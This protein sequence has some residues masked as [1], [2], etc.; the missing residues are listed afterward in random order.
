MKKILLLSFLLS[1]IFINAQQEYQSL[2]WEITGNSLEKPSYLY[3]TMHVSK[4]V[5]FRLDDVFYESLNKSECIAL[6]SDPSTWLA[7]NY[8]SSYLLNSYEPYN[9]DFYA[10]LFK[11]NHPKQLEIRENIRID[12]NQISGYLYRK[13][14]ADDN[15]EEETYLDMFIYQAG[16]KHNKTIVGLENLDESKYLTTKAQ[17]DDSKK[18]DA[19]LV[20]LFKE[21]RPYIVQE[22]TYRERNLD[23]LDSIG[24]ASS[25][26]FYREHMLY[27]RND[28]MVS[29]L[30]SLMHKKSVFSGVGAAHLPGKKGMINM[31]RE[32]GYIVKPLISNQTNFAEKEK[33]K[34]E[35]LFKKPKLSLQSTPDKFLTINSFDVLREYAFENKKF[36]LSPDMTNG[37]FLTISRINT[38]EYLPHENPI[39]LKKINDL[40]YEDV[41]G[42]IIRKEELIHPYPG[43][44]ILNK[45]KKGDYQKYHIYKTP[46]EIII[47]K[48]G[49]KK[50]FVLNY[51]ENIF[52]TITFQEKTNDISTYTDAHNKYSIVFPKYHVTDNT[53]NNGK[54]L[55]QGKNNNEYYFIQESP[56]HDLDYIE[57]D[58]FEAKHIHQ[59]FYKN[60]KI[61]ETKGNLKNSVYKSYESYAKIDSISNKKIFL[62]SIVKDASY[63]LLG[64]VG[65][66]QKKADDYFKS[67]KFKD[68]NYN[69]FKKVIDTSLHFSALT[70]AKPKL[71][72]SYYSNNKRKS[73]LETNKSTSYKT[74]ANE[75]IFVERTKYHDLQM[76]ENID[77]LWNSIDR[78]YKF[79]NLFYLQKKLKIYDK[80]K[81]AKN[82]MYTYSFKIKDS[83]SSKIISIKNIVKQGV[84]FELKTLS[85][86]LSKPSKFLTSFYDSFTPIDT[87]LGKNIFKDK[88]QIF[89]KALR[90]N[91]S[92][93]LRPYS[94]IKFK[95]HD[96]DSIIDIIKNFNFAED[97]LRLKTYLID[98]LGD[99]N[100]N[101]IAPFLKDL[102][103]KSYSE[104][105]IQSKI[106]TILLSKKNIESYDLILELMDKDLPLNSSYSSTHF[107]TI[108][109]SLQLKKHLFPDILKYT[110]IEEYKKPIYNLLTSLK[111]SSIVKPKLYK[112]YRN[113]IINDAKIEVK[114][115]LN[116]NKNSTY[117]EEPDAF[118]TSYVKLVFP[119]RKE[120]SVNDFFEKLLL[121]DDFIALTEYYILLKQHDEYIPKTLTKKT[122]QDSKNLWY[123]IEQLSKKKLSFKNYNISQKEFAKSK[124]FSTLNI[125]DKDSISF[126]SQKEF[127]TDKDES[128]IMYFYKQKIKNPT[129]TE[130]NLHY[131][132]FKK[133][134]KNK[135]NTKAFYKS[136]Q[137]GDY[138]TEEKTEEEMIDDLIEITKHV[139][140]KRINTNYSLF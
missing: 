19:W 33:N 14:Y 110:S 20:K 3:G 136:K 66:N 126:I 140:R 37:A 2:L 139:T 76:F 64:Y 48:F 1:T 97:R 117:Y 113:Q 63:Y 132:A 32:K 124:L 45:T 138:I 49:G 55:I 100:N 30:D 41:P 8:E 24:E 130:N 96:T 72:Y 78:R 53:T 122:I 43:F 68:I 109:D 62:K 95:N 56:I 119:F 91:D 115:S 118:L 70:N 15:F 81:T 17:Y 54:K 35:N 23:L 77:S 121:S 116:F 16:K 125:T 108:N 79:K 112:K 59:A 105:R 47:I 84:H 128:I 12:N 71:A 99:L 58:V 73:Y 101:K 61:K 26:N 31:L 82:D 86:S 135:L 38:F 107:L 75:V 6:E 88:T 80:K 134:K 92:L 94:K 67:F 89:F 133:A 93:A 74:K 25:T 9:E 51:E 90:E 103:I 50:D 44:S 10:D 4:K 120:K 52:N 39:S 57:E 46:F 60:L 34:L 29:V 111:D 102:Y 131:I 13:N 129:Y 18:P 21:Q 123:T 104:P 114:R 42:D 98:Q 36:Y 22:N 11:L 106:L 28:N 85:D 83:L 27:K 40:L 7:Y 127:K 65:E 87:L 5:A 69:A 137:D